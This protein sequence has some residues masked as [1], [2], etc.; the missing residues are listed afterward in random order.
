[1]DA[2]ALQILDMVVF[3][4]CRKCQKCT[5]FNQ[6][7]LYQALSQFKYS[8]RSVYTPNCAYTVYGGLL[9]NGVFVAG[10][11]KLYLLCFSRITKLYHQTVGKQSPAKGQY[12]PHEVEESSN[13]FALH[14]MSRVHLVQSYCWYQAL[15]KRL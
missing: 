6:F 1:M 13:V 14:Y 5:D 9:L 8:V 10:E 11:K 15:E 2:V 12:P 4:N 7:V 3:R